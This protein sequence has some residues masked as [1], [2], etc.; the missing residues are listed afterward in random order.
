[1]LRTIAEALG[2][3]RER[4]PHPNPPPLAREGVSTDGG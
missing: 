4:S 1:V 3:P 2:R